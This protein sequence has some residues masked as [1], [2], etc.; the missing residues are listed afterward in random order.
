[1]IAQ[2]P[3][4]HGRVYGW[5]KAYITIHKR[6]GVIAAGIYAKNNIPPQFHDQLNI[7]VKEMSRESK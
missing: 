4:S 7:L 6:E 1:M 5:A 2:F 3:R